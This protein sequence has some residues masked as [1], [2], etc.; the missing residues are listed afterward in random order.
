MPSSRNNGKK[1]AR[2]RRGLLRRPPGTAL[3]GLQRRRRMRLPHLPAA[4]F[5][6]GP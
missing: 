2:A 6:R 5:Q 1:A 4:Y 3:Q